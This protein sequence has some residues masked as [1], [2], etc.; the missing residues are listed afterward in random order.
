MIDRV[1][2]NKALSKSIRHDIIERADGIPLFVEEITKAVLE[3]EGE[4]AAEEHCRQYSIV[5]HYRSCK[6]PRL[7]DGTA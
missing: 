7:A 5:F 1:T 4:E 3:A 6:P 2:G